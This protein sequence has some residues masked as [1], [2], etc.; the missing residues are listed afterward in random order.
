M[1][2]KFDLSDP[3]ADE[4]WEEEWQRRNDEL[5]ALDAYDPAEADPAYL[6]FCEEQAAIHDGTATELVRCYLC[7][8]N[9][10]LRLAKDAGPLRG[11]LARSVTGGS[12]PTEMLS[13]S[14]GHEVI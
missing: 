12:D 9:V 13:L 14:C 11:V 4:A 7:E 8:P 10:N 5:E 2:T 6:A 1:T 3:N